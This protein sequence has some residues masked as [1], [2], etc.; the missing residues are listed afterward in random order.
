MLTNKENIWNKKLEGYYE[1]PDE[2]LDKNNLETFPIFK[3]FFDSLNSETKKESLSMGSL[4][5]S[6][7]NNYSII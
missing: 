2:I 4:H 1:K 5:M 7:L 3:K 6:R